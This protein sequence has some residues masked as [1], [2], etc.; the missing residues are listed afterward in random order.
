MSNDRAPVADTAEI[1]AW[2]PSPYSLTQYVPATT[3]FAGTSSPRPYTGGRWKVLL[4]GTQE[5]YLPMADG[6]F[7]STGNHPVE[8]LLPLLHL[9]AAG[10][11]VDVATPSGG[12]VKLEVWAFPSRDEAVTQIYKKYEEKLR[13]PLSLEALWEGSSSNGGFD[14][15]T[16]YLAVFVPGGH[17]VLNDIPRSRLVGDVLRWAHAQDRY[18]VTLC[19]GPAALLAAEV[20]APAGSRFLYDGYEVVAFPD[21]LDQGTNIDIGYIPGKM[22]WLVGEALRKRGVKT[23]NEG[24]TGRVHRDRLLL[25]GDSPLASNALGKL[26]AETLLEAVAKRG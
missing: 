7:F 5:R 13:A 17:G 9:D 26:A 8:L 14:A 23:L 1:N 10:F 3:D 25:T 24:I 2:F 18:V 21:A 20:G 15:S 4:I 6:R 11:D 16:P 19:H 22:Q 12:P